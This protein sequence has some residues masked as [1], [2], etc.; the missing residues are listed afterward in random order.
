MNHQDHELLN[1]STAEI[2]ELAIIIY[3]MTELLN[4]R[5]IDLLDDRT[6]GFFRRSNYRF[7]DLLNYSVV[8]SSK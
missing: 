3:K 5:T 4:Y 8:V 7:S 6:D 2:L 1:C